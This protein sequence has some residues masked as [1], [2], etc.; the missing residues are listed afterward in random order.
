MKANSI[1]LPTRCAHWGWVDH[2]YWGHAVFAEL[3]GRE[4]LTG[5]LALSVV[6]RRLSKDCCDVLDD[7][8]CVSTLADPRIWPLKLT[9][10]VA[11]YGS[12]MPAVAAG[13]L[14]LQTARIGPWKTADA[15]AVLVELHDSIGGRTDDDSIVRRKV[16]VFLSKHRMISGF[17]APFHE[18]DERLVALRGCMRTRE[19]DQLPYWRTMDAVARAVLSLRELYPN[20]ALGLAAAFLDMGMTTAEVGPLCTILCQHMFFANAVEGAQ[21]SPPLLRDL[22]D[23]HISYV[24]RAP[25]ISPKGN[26]RACGRAISQVRGR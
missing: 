25:R 9:R 16:E 3:A 1:D 13:L 17:G 7:I 18:H 23:C 22:P 26:A 24:G 6:G 10:L 19:R 11:A 4:S 15:A 20:L 2:Q 14:I 5:L 8:A 12:T 21:Q